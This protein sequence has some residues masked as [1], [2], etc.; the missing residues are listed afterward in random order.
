MKHEID[1]QQTA[2]ADEGPKPPGADGRSAKVAKGTRLLQLLAEEVGPLRLRV[3]LARGVSSFLPQFHFNR[4]RTALWRTAEV[5]MGNGSLLMGDLVVSGSGDWSSSLLTI[6]EET[7]V[8]GPLRINLGGA[9]RIGNRVN[10]GHDCFFGTV[11][12]EIGNRWR[13]AGTVTCSEI[14]IEDGVW[15]TSRVTILPGVT[16]GEGS[17]VAAGAVVT[18]DVPAHTLVGGVPARVLRNLS[19]S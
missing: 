7:Y 15:I 10:I 13:R 2:L 11:G 14:V 9:V 3:Q 18:S 19:A 17:I 6:G 16:V 5:R 8:T 12:H 1:C 4:L